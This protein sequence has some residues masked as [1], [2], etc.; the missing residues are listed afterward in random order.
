MTGTSPGK[1]CRTHTQ[2]ICSSNRPGGSD[3]GRGAVPAC[4]RA[5]RRRGRLGVP[6][7]L[8]TSDHRACVPNRSSRFK[9]PRRDCRPSR[10]RS[11]PVFRSTSRCSSLT[12]STWGGP[13]VSA[14]RQAAHRCRPGPGGGLGRQWIDSSALAADP[15]DRRRA[16]RMLGAT[17][18]S[19]GDQANARRLSRR[20]Q[21]P[22]RDDPSNA[23]GP[24]SIWPPECQLDSVAD[25][26]AAGV[27]RSGPWPSRS[28]LSKV[29]R[30]ASTGSVLRRGPTRCYDGVR[31]IKRGEVDEGG[32]QTSHCTRSGADLSGRRRTR[33]PMLT[34]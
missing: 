18:H 25:P 26:L 12:T 4:L 3:P 8:A 6:R 30:L 17:L 21:S 19:L 23:R 2:R 31:L 16:E 34:V 1:R 20:N 29:G 13:R 15:A 27:P 22:R 7:D 28:A 24:F 10:T 14:Q 32:R 9:A 5:D 33:L 11:L